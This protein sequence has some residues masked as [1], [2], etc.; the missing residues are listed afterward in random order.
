MDYKKQLSDYFDREIAA[1]KSLNLN[2]I[3]TVLNVLEAA[4]QND[5]TIFICGNGGSA[6]TASH[7]VCDF[8][9]GVS[10][11]QDKK[12]R[13]DCLNDNVPLMM[14]TA[15]DLSYD[16]IFIVPLKNKLQKGDVF[17]GISGSGNSVN[18]IKAMEY[19]KK[20]GAV[21]IAMTGYNGGKLK[22]LADYS[23]HININNMQ[24]AEDIHMMMDHVMMYTL[25]HSTVEENSQDEANTQL[26]L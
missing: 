3:N 11:N 14:A 25:C 9:K 7:F 18:V 24:I 5:Q 8:N 6:A 22:V 19:A 26:I 1:I 17:F 12:Y 4:R 13:F 20:Q 10:E 23:I 15:N 21:T 2:E 16:D